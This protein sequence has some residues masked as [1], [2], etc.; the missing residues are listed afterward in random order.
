MR[1]IMM[2]ANSPL[3]K[4][5]EWSSSSDDL[6]PGMFRSFDGGVYVQTVDGQIEVVRGDPAYLIRRDEFWQIV[7]RYEIQN[8]Y[9][10]EPT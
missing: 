6:L 1:E 2:R 3:L 4:M 7:D 9:T 8:H 10:S 5:V